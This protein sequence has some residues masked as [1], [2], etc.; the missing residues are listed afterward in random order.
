MIKKVRG[1]GAIIKLEDKPP[2]KCRKWQ[3]RVSTGLDP[4]TGKYRSRTK[5]FTGTYTEAQQE[6]REFTGAVETGKSSAKTRYTVGT[7]IDEYMSLR[8]ASG[9]YAHGTLRKNDDHFKCVKM[10]I[11]Y[12]NIATVT[13]LTLE[14]LYADMRN[15]KS[16]SGKKL[17]GTYVSCIHTSLY[18][19]FEHAKDHDIISSNPCVKAKQPKPDTAEKKAMTANGIA[20]FISALDHTEPNHIALLLC[21]TMGI[22]RGEALALCWEDANL[23]ERYILISKSIDESGTIKTAKTKASVRKLPIPEITFDALRVRKASQRDEMNAVYKSLMELGIDPSAAVQKP[24]TPIVSGPTG[25]HI[26]PHSISTWW[27]RN[28]ASF[29]MEGWTIHELRH[30]YLSSLAMAGIHPKVM[31]ELAGH[32]SSKTTMDIYSHVNMDAKKAATD[33]FESLLA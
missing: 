9:E 32:A 24:S 16:P 4:A 20:S 8:K 29:G 6:L 11:G 21:A 10:L 19:L 3:L 28:R 33:I 23:G 22:R 18:G 7:Y 31:Q 1:E 26:L 2:S 17:S 15:G 25:N 30:S 14:K 5:R 27:R 12:S 13:P